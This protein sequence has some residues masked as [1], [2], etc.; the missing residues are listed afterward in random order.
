MADLSV[1]P[2]D[3]T[4]QLPR[5]AS[6]VDTHHSQ[7]LEEAET[8]QCRRGKDLTAGAE[9]QDDDAS[10]YDH[11]I[12]TQFLYFSSNRIRRLKYDHN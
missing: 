7:N 10:R 11:H 6:P 4:E 12:C 1:S 8:T 5:S 9:T 3:G 2:D